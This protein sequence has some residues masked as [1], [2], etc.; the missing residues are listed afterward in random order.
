[1][2]EGRTNAFGVA[3]FP[4]VTTVSGHFSQQEVDF[5]RL[6]AKYHP[7]A[8]ELDLFT[9]VLESL[10]FFVKLNEEL[11]SGR[12][13][14]PKTWLNGSIMTRSVG[15]PLPTDLDP[16]RYHLL[17]DDDRELHLERGRPRLNSVGRTDTI[18]SHRTRSSARF[19][20]SV[21]RHCA[22][23]YGGDSLRV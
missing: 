17:H 9:L 15:A 14:I 22:T 7:L 12:P 6:V 18:R 5:A 23:L 19:R 4:G 11:E 2:A 16:E 21:R 20:G 8:R 10:P 3:G 1:M 13:W